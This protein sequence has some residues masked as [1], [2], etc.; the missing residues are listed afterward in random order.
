MEV[1]KVTLEWQI[2]NLSGGHEPPIAYTIY[3]DGKKI[4]TTP[5]LTYQDMAPYPNTTYD[6]CVKANY[7]GYASAPVCLPT[8]TDLYCLAVTPLKTSVKDKKITLYWSAPEFAPEKYTILRDGVFLEETTQTVVIDN[9]PKENTEY[10]YCV[11]A[12]YDGCDSDPSCIKAKSGIVC[13]VIDNFTATVNVLSITLSWNHISPNQLMKYV[14]TRDDAVIHE[15]TETSYTDTVTEENTEYE[16]CITAYF[17]N[18]ISDEK[19]EIVKS[20]TTTGIAEEQPE[21]FQIYPNPAHDYITVTG[22]AMQ[23]IF[24][25]DITGKIVRE[26]NPNSAAQSNISVLGL[27]NG[28]YLLR[29]H[30]EGNVFVKRFSVMK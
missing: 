19:C 18:C 22:A 30:S 1:T 12:H 13:G 20:G 3:R 15:T 23:Q 10:E 9:V 4:G 8:T 28:L 7:T 25:Y 6:Y 5:S 16:Y 14:I 29:I 26:I 21:L 2:P 17:D 11:I 27:E 24:I